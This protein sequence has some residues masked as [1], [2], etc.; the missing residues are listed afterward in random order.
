[1]A[2]PVLAAITVTVGQALRVSVMAELL[3]SPDGVGA[4]IARSRANLDTAQLFAW[5]GTFVVT[6]ITVETLLLRP[7]SRYSLRWREAAAP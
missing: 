5:A 3:A 4:L 2:S 7:L 1:M 6:V